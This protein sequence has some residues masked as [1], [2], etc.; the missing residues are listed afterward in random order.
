MIST[1][2]ILHALSHVQDPDLK[3]DLVTLGMIKNVQVNGEKVSFTVVLTTPACPLKEKIRQDCIRAIWQMVRPNL[4]VE[5]EM[6]SNVTSQNASPEL[7]S[8]K[9]I[10]AVV[11]GKGGVGKSTVAANL[12][13]AMAR[14]GARVALVDA[15]VHGP[16]I[17]ILFGL[18][19]ARPYVVKRG[20]REL[21][22]PIEKHGVFLNS[23]GF[24][25][26]PKKALVMRGPLT[27][28]V[29][30]QLIFDTDWQD[31][32]YM[33]VDMPPGTGD[34]HMTLV[35]RLSVTG[36]VLVTTPQE[37]ALADARKG[38]QMFLDPEV[39]V[40]ILGIVENMAYFVPPDM[41]DK[42]Y[43]IF[44]EGGGKILA[45]ELGTQV[46]SHIPIEMLV[47]ERSDSGEPVALKSDTETGKAFQRLGEEVARQI[48]IRNSQLP[49]S[50]KVRIL[51]Q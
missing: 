35:Q 47:R 13:V 25:V 3:K 44:G 6:T 2:Q 19:D 20:E 32:D 24:L 27:G 1:E 37:V 42:K 11:S 50:Q 4:E 39:N 41:P 8:V 9:N 28:K 34:L 21:M 48:A 49:P 36:V 17:P 51:H 12:A 26:D 29:L 7:T 18:P 45:E 10:I 33:I 40:P 38:G 43:F 30:N 23:V 14:S 22:E 15:D 46:L 31:I 16:S 5:V